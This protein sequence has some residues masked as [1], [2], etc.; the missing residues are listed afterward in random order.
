[1]TVKLELDP[2]IESQIKAQAAE[3]GVPI[4][5]YLRDIIERCAAFSEW[6]EDNA[7]SAEHYRLALTCETIAANTL[8]PEDFSDWE[9]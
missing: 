1:M 6:H 9:K 2:E 7:K 4:E 8:P 5:D 3:R